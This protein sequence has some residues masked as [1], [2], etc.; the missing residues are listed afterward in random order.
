MLSGSPSSPRIVINSENARLNAPVGGGNSAA[1]QSKY[2]AELSFACKNLP[3]LD[4]V[5]KTD[6]KVKLY[7]KRNEQWQ[8]VVVTEVVYNNLN[9]EFAKSVKVDFYFETK[10]PFK[11]EVYH[12]NSETEEV[13][14]GEV[15]FFLSSLL[16]CK[17]DT[18]ELQI[19]DK[20]TKKTGLGSFYVRWDKTDSSAMVSLKLSAQNIPSVVC[21]WGDNLNMLE[22]YKPKNLTVIGPYQPGME[23][24]YYT[25]NKDKKDQW[26]LVHRSDRIN[27]NSIASWQQMEQNKAKL[28]SDNE[29]FPLKIE[30]LHYATNSGNHKLIGGTVKSFQELRAV[31]GNSLVLYDNKGQPLSEAKLRVDVCTQSSLSVNLRGGVQL[32][33]LSQRRPQHLL[34]S[35]H[36]LHR[37][38]WCGHRPQ[39]SPLCQSQQS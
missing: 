24:T 17:D 29:N 13:Y 39:E 36:R 35:R 9:P 33:G 16:G 27:K 18:L 26:V 7:E 11:A 5:T 30:I 34:V 10:Q 4:V 20:R 14:M 25:A 37:F 12:Q 3:D 32:L 19:Q 31:V 21:C 23:Q 1:L 6:P 22:I 15:E 28:C 8:L 38:E 2:I